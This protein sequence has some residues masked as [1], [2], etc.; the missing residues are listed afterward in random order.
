MHIEKFTFDNIVFA[1]IYSAHTKY[2]QEIAEILALANYSHK[3][4]VILLSICQYD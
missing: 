1:F 4:T 2:K 3:L